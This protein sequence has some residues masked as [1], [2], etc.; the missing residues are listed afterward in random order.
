M[1]NKTFGI[2]FRIVK[3]EEFD[4]P[5]YKVIVFDDVY[6]KSRNVYGKMTKFVE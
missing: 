1:I 5:K 6:F 2:S 4:F 3:L